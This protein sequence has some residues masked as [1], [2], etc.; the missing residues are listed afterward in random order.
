MT[1]V[2]TRLDALDTPVL[3]VDLDTLEGN[4]ALLAGK[5]RAAGVAW[6]PH[7]KG[8]KIPAIAHLALR[9]GA[10]GVTC[11]K[12][13]EAEVMAAAGIQDILIANQIVGPRKA[14]RLARLRRQADVKVAVDDLANARELGEAARARGVEVGVVIEVD[15]G[16]ERAGVQPGQPTVALARLIHAT[17]GLRL[18]GLMGWEGHTAHLTDPVEKRPR[19]EEAI[20]RLTATAEACR[21]AGL[22][23]DIVSCS[24]SVTYTI[25]AHLPGI[26]EVQAGGGMLGDV[27][28]R[29]GA[30]ETRPGLFVRAAVT[31]RPDTRRLIFDA[32]FKSLP[33]WGGT[34]EPQGLANVAAVLASAEHLTVTL[35]APNDTA[36]IG[37]QFDF[38]VGYGDSTV[39]LYDQLVGVRNGCVEVVWP[40]LGRGRVQ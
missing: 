11:A 27:Y 37:D 26:T 35:T 25:S 2:D 30:A 4:I 19:V 3:W 7:T 20:G 18:R 38:L 15:I 17:P 36:R 8:I 23:V 32:G 9:A 22:P 10:I 13:G 5:I 29:N 24:G 1:L 39:F 28:Y 12:L 6:R 34:P 14:A 33:T 21:A 16:M 40:I 31:S